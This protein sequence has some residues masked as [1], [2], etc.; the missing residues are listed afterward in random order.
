MVKI[1]SIFVALENTNFKM[2]NFILVQSIPYPICKYFKMLIS[3]QLIWKSVRYKL[4]F[5]HK[6]MFREAM[7]VHSIEYCPSKNHWLPFT[8][9]TQWGEII[10]EKEFLFWL[11][12]S[13]YNI[14]LQ[15][16][17]LYLSIDIWYV[18]NIMVEW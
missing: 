12:P 4:E 15:F 6:E 13:L 3:I 1:S 10:F 7:K 11:K 2:K 16:S 5:S 18:M 14:F 9:C 8:S 17:L